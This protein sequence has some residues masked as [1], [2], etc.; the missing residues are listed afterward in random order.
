LLLVDHLCVLKPR[1]IRSFYSLE[2]RKSTH[3][4]LPP[5]VQTPYCTLYTTLFQHREIVSIVFEQENSAAAIAQI[6]SDVT[7]A[8]HV[9]STC[10]R[11]A[12]S[13]ATGMTIPTPRNSFSSNYTQALAPSAKFTVMA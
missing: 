1:G 11:V 5:T 12:P 6:A 8:G 13:I 3:E 4:R 2:L 9:L 10:G 7:Y